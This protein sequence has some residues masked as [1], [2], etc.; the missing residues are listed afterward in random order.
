[1][2]FFSHNSCLSCKGLYSFPQVVKTCKKK[3]K[4]W[5]Q[6][7]NFEIAKTSAKCPNNLGQALTPF[8]NFF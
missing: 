3:E 2:H 6:L 8:G 7:L 5:C 4:D 1:M